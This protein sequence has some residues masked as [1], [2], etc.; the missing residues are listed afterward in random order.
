MSWNSKF[1]DRLGQVTD[2]PADKQGGFP[3]SS[4]VRDGCFEW[5]NGNESLTRFIATW[6]DCGLV[7]GV[8]HSHWGLREDG[9]TFRHFRENS[10]QQTRRAKREFFVTV[11]F[12]L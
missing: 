2:I 10:G 11:I 1:D 7:N 12:G 4:D 3:R 5:N 9:T 6:D 8:I